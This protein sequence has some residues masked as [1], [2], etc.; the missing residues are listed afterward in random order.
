MQKVVIR[1]VLFPY[2]FHIILILLYLL[3]STSPHRQAFFAYH[4]YYLIVFQ[5]SLPTYRYTNT[6]S[7]T[8]M[9]RILLLYIDC[10]SYIILHS[11]MQSSILCL[12]LVLCFYFLVYSRNLSLSLQQN[13]PHSYFYS[14][15]ISIGESTIIYTTLSSMHIDNFQYFA[16]RSDFCT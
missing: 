9:H 14:H 8:H 16:V 15:K 11:Y 6:Q 5:K 7:Y 12:L 4:L 1:K 3:F 2:H 10:I 13:P